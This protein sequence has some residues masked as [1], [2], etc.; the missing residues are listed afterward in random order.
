MNDKHKLPK[1]FFTEDYPLYE[2]I[3]AENFLIK[4]EHGQSKLRYTP[5]QFGKGL[6]RTL[7]SM[8]TDT[9]RQLMNSIQMEE[10]QHMSREERMKHINWVMERL[11][12]YILDRAEHLVEAMEE[13]YDYQ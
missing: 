3:G 12:T 10:L 6:D 11:N 7:K 5:E 13:L 1:T 9:E 4:L 8:F 2:R